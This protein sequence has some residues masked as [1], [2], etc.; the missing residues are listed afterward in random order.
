MMK[1]LNIKR[2]GATLAFGL[3]VSPAFSQA[4]VR[5]NSNGLPFDETNKMAWIQAHPAEYQNLS[6]QSPERINTQMTE[7]EKKAWILS[8]PAEYAKMN[9]QGTSFSPDAN[10]PKFVNTGNPAADMQAY[11]EAKAAYKAAHGI[12]VDAASDP[13][14]PVLKNTGNPEADMAEYNKAKDAYKAANGL[15]GQTK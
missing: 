11:N 9:G 2:L 10:A 12:P 14:R 6:T 3:L 4:P 5:N 13:T 8:H 15:N 1:M 7:E